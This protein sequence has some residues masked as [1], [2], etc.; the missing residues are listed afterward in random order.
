MGVNASSN[1][2]QAA[3]QQ[4]APPNY[5][6]QPQHR[7]N[8][9]FTDNQKM[10][11]PISMVPGV[12]ETAPRAVLTKALFS[13]GGRPIVSLPWPPP[14]VATPGFTR[15][16]A[17]IRIAAH[18]RFDVWNVEY[19]IELG[20]MA[21]TCSLCQKRSMKTKCEGQVASIS[22]HH[23]LPLHRTNATCITV[24]QNATTLLQKNCGWKG[25][26]RGCFGPGT[27]HVILSHGLPAKG[28]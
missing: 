15:E 16:Q 13:L 28:A 1:Q 17:L 2:Q 19:L 4:S 21:W 10:E 5:P 26:C 22:I 27:R 20:M 12:A 24:L 3:G 25:V 6:P 14:M 23:G 18:Q 8:L 11:L 7:K 9:I